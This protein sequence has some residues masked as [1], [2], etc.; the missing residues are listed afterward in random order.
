MRGQR[1]RGRLV[2]VSGAKK[3][4]LCFYHVYQEFEQRKE[5]VR[6][7]HINATLLASGFFLPSMC[8]A[9]RLVHLFAYTHSKVKGD[10]RRSL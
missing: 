5:G 6:K 7:R 8:Q 1:W 2:E 3:A 4:P 10:Q 9:T